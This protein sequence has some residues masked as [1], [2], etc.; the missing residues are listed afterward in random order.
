MGD[1]AVVAFGGLGLAGLALVGLGALRGAPVPLVFGS[2]LLVALAGL[3]TLGLYGT[4]V[5]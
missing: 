5:G 1:V 2:G 4:L 3:W